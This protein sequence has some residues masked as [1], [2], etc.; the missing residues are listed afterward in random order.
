M[1][2]IILDNQIINALTLLEFRVIKA[3]NFGLYDINK[4]IQGYLGKIIDVLYFNALGKTI[5]LDSLR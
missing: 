1:D 4:K 3:N 2:S 5:D